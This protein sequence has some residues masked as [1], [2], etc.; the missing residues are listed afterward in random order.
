[1]K[2]WLL[3]GGAVILYYVIKTMATSSKQ[4]VQDNNRPSPENEIRLTMT[5]SNRM[6]AN[7]NRDDDDLATFSISYGHEEEKSKNKTQGKWIKSGEYIIIKGQT[8]T[9]GNFYF[10]GVLSSL[11]GYETEASLVDDLLKI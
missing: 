8:I 2:F 10:G 4:K 9:G 5:T 11:D 3:V 7:S 6:V 1:M